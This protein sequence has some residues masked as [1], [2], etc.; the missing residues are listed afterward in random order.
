MVQLDELIRRPDGDHLPEGQIRIENPELHLTALYFA[1][2]FRKKR[3][4]GITEELKELNEEML[5]HF[6]RGKI[7]CCSTER[8]T[9][10]SDSER[11]GRTNVSAIIYRFK[12]LTSLIKRKT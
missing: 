5:A 4:G 10:D 11:K 2:E 3:E 1:Q 12:N 6:R 9:A 8:R 7:Y